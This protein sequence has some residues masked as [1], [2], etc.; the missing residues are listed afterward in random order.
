MPSCPHCPDFQLNVCFKV[1]DAVFVVAPHIKREMGLPF[2][3]FLREICQLF[4]VSRR[5]PPSGFWP[6]HPIPPPPI[7]ESVWTPPLL[8]FL[9]T[10]P[11]GVH[12]WSGAS[13]AAGVLPI[14][15][16][17]SQPKEAHRGMVLRACGRFCSLVPSSQ[18]VT[19]PPLSFARV[20]LCGGS[21]A[22]W[23]RA[24]FSPPFGLACCGRVV[25]MQITK[26]YQPVGS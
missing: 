12:G 15:P 1:F 20:W 13:D 18:G 8:G 14:L 5:T 24:C 26:L 17:L 16:P 2:L 22:A 21:F 9:W 10:V 6:V 3:R 25:L 7:L 23:A 11:G 19:P 4:C